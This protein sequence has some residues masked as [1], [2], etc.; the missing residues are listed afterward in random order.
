M[1]DTDRLFFHK[2]MESQSQRLPFSVPCNTRRPPPEGRTWRGRNTNI[3]DGCG[4]R[5]RE[6]NPPPVVETL[7]TRGESTQVAV[8]VLRNVSR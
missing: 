7:E 1:L 6:K 3:N 4:T 8:P 2:V 5:T